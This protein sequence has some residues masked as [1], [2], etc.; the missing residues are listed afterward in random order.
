[1]ISGPR[2]R[3]VVEGIGSAVP[4]KVMTN[5][6][7]EQLVETSD[8][9]IVQRTGIRERRISGPEET[10]GTL[11]LQ[12]ARKALQDAKLNPEELDLIVVATVDRKSVV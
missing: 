12:A 4:S 6:D 9:W 8:E 1:M 7:F 2:I 5:H 3:A 11:S 10:S